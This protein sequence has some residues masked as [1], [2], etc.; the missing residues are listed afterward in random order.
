M[1]FVTV[2]DE[3]SRRIEQQSDKKTKAEIM[4]I[5]K[6]MFGKDDIPE[7]ETMLVP[8]WWSNRL[9][10][11]SYSN[12]P[13]GYTH[14]NYQDLQQPLGRI[15]FAGEHT[16]STYLGYVDGAYFSGSFYLWPDFSLIFR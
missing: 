10:K 16:N 12:W 14:H 6:K 15:Y 3:E 9:F 7:P 11:G 4:H 5:L 1:L 8:R 13:N 2:T